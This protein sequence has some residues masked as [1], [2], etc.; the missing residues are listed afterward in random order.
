V[1]T[2]QGEILQ[3]KKLSILFLA[4]V[5]FSIMGCSDKAETTTQ[6]TQAPQQAAP[7]AGPASQHGKV[8]EATQA[9]MYTYIKVD[10]GGKEL[11][12]AASAV[13]ANVGDT[14]SWTGG[15]MMQNFTSKSMRRTFDQI[16]FVDKVAVVKG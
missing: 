4:S 10:S 9:G 2:T 3:V 16:L 1:A 6:A 8:L 5:L 7:A 15:A 12:M 11:W 13:K 14:V